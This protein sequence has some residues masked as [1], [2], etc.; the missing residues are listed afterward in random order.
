MSGLI[1]GY[2]KD[3]MRSDAIAGVTTAA[4]VIPKSMA[5]ATIA[6][7]ETIPPGF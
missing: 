1:A 7:G 2:N 5:L 4:V 3:W 6:G